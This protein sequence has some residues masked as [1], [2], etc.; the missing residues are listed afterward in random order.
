MSVSSQNSDRPRPPRRARGEARVTALLDAAERVFATSGY[1]A[2]TM[3]AIAAAAGASIGSLYQFFPTREAVARGVLERCFASLYAELEALAAAPS[4]AVG[5]ADAIAGVMARHATARAAGMVLLAEGPASAQGV[6]A[7]I[8]AG[9]RER[10]ARALCA[11]APG[12]DPGRAAQIAVMILQMSK[13]VILAPGERAEVDGLETAFGALLRSAL[14][15]WLA[16]GLDQPGGSSRQ[17]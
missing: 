6:R 8:R 2:A 16:P 1:T 5:L 4:D 3:T 12:L 14:P 9:L 15:V 10:V 13:S 11:A 7:E 17:A